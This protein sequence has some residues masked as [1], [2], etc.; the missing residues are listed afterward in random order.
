LTCGTSCTREIA[1]FPESVIVM[2]T[3]AG[4]AGVGWGPV[5][6]SPFVPGALAGARAHA[7]VCLTLRRE[8]LRAVVTG[9]AVVGR[10]VRVRAIGSELT[11]SVFGTAV[12]D[13]ARTY[14]VTIAADGS[15]TVPDLVPSVEDVR[16]VLPPVGGRRVVLMPS[17][18]ATVNP[19]D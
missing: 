3:K 4:R 14:D 5:E 15:I 6:K 10:T 18:A 1:H 11:H 17:H 8:P 12:A 16:L 13:I 9:G 7:T 19:V 2:A